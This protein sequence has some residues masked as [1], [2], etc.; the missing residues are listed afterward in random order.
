MLIRRGGLVEML[1]YVRLENF[2]SHK[3]TTIEFSD[4]LNVFIGK[5][6]SGKSSVI[7]AI[8]Y[9]LYGRHGRGVNSNIVRSNSDRGSVELGIIINNRDY[10]IYRE[11]NSKGSPISISLKE[12][13]RV[14]AI[15]GKAR[16]GADE[17]GI[18]KRIELLLGLSYDDVNIA[19]IIKQGELDAIID[20][21]PREIKEM[22]NR[23]TELDRLDKA[24]EIFRDILDRFRE[25][26]K[27]EIGYDESDLDRI[28]REMD[29]SEKGLS[30]ANDR[31]NELKREMDEKSIRKRD[32]EENLKTMEL[33]KSRYDEY[34]H[35][36]NTLSR[37][38]ES[39]SKE[40]E[41]RYSEIR[42]VIREGRRMLSIAREEDVVKEEYN[43]IIEIEKKAEERSNLEQIKSVLVRKM[44]STKREIEDIE[45]RLKRYSSI[46]VVEY[47]LHQI[48]MFI[49]DMSKKIEEINEHI[50]E[51]NK[52]MHDCNTMLKDGVCPTCGREVDLD[53][54]ERLEHI[55]RD[56]ES[57]RRK[58][59]DLE[60]REETMRKM[61]R[62]RREYE[63]A[64]IEKKRLEEELEMKE[65][66]YENDLIHYKELDTKLSSIANYDIKMLREKKRE[67]EEKRRRIENAKGWLDAKKIN[68]EHDIKQL[69]E[70]LTQIDNILRRLKSKRLDEL[71]IDQHATELIERMTSIKSDAE[72]FDKGIHDRLHQEFD[73]INKEL[74]SLMYMKGGIESDIDSVK[75][76]LDELRKVRE[77][78]IVGSRYMEFYK[79]IRDDIYHKR[80]P[81]ILRGWVFDEL[82]IRASEYLSIF[83]IGISTLR[84]REEKN[85]V[86]MSCHGASDL[87]INSLSGGEKVAI[88]LALRFAISSLRGAINTDFIILDEPTTHLDQERRRSLVKLISKLA[89]YESMLRQIILITHDAE[90]FEDAEIDNI[91]KFEKYGGISRVTVER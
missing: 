74:N 11:F 55:K 6:G 48:G 91:I 79:S 65:R 84:I 82:S 4:G 41:K 81:Q 20:L 66:E 2:L 44:D 80:L 76:R 72:R 46:E 71:A 70:E 86:V 50:G 22:I 29:D 64:Q 21:K 31:L 47:D 39:K 62:K 14:I 68:S 57:L 69:E 24:Y 56:L 15:G 87:D 53:V 32:I 26:M 88:S 38:L 34:K 73:E 58:R 40:Y 60:E 18:A 8:T 89:G 23:L 61:E 83:D 49:K 37:Y 59:E 52:L 10:N 27:S 19:S 45:N 13:G 78:L 51:M 25:R 33:L 54:E 17:E 36:H 35:L 75:K 1:K 77:E 63:D 43:K 28:E 67:I 30:D 12:D 3:D 42:D 9:A 90:I 16:R 7:D 5:N 85:D